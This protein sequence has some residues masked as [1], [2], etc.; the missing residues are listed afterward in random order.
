MSM[1]WVAAG[2]SESLV[3]EMVFVFEFVVVVAPV[4]DSNNKSM[5]SSFRFVSKMTDM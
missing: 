4:E 2:L 1:A 3:V 5:H